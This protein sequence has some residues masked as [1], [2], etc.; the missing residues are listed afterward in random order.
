MITEIIDIRQ[1]GARQFRPL[2]LAESQ[3]WL[4]GLHWD[5]TPSAELISAY[6]NEKRLSGFVL[7]EDKCLTGYCLYFREGPKGM[8]GDLFVVGHHSCANGVA[9]L[10]ERTIDTL[11]GMPDVRRIEAQLPHLNFGQVSPYFHARSFQVYARQFM[12]FHFTN[13]TEHLQLATHPA[14]SAIEAPLSSSDFQFEPWGRRYDREA[15]QLLHHAYQNHI[16]A[17]INDQYCTLA[18]TRR[19]IES[20]VRQRGCGDYLDDASTVAIHRSTGRL[21]GILGLTVVR[22]GTAHIPQIAVATPFQG[23]GLGTA[24]LQ[25]SFQKLREAGFLEVSLTVTSLNNRAVRLYE[26]LGFRTFRE[27]GA[28]VWDRPQ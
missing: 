27:F 17:A 11:A 7:L 22:S 6:L 2:L 13:G 12:A 26:R 19:L 16:D 24:M 14:G 8:I 5:Y 15:A 1:F 3:A 20:I 21:A 10:L 28:F 25:S 23:L 4:E 9:P 18:G